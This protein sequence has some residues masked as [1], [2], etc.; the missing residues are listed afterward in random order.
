MAKVLKGGKEVEGEF[1][2]TEG[3]AKHNDYWVAWKSPEAKRARAFVRQEARAKLSP[4]EQMRVLNQ[5]LG[6]AIGARKER[7]RL[8]ALMD[9]ASKKKK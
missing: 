2:V 7:D 3:Q 6:D 5:R 1:I 4:I 8:V 9:D